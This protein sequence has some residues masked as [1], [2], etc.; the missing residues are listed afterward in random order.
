MRTC[1]PIFVLLWLLS[2]PARAQ[3]A[4]EAAREALRTGQYEDAR[5]RFRVLLEAPDEGATAYAAG[6]ADAFLK[7]GA[8]DEGL[9]AFEALLPRHPGN[10]DLLLA[11]S[12]L[13]VAR[14]RYA[15]AEAALTQA[16]RA[17]SDCWACAYVLGRLFED[18][19][20][21]RQA[22]RL[23]AAVFRRYQEGAFGTADD[24]G[25]AAR[26]AARL[27][28]FRDANEAFR[29]A[30]RMD[31]RH[32]DNLGAW[33]ALFQEKYNTA[34]AQ[35]TYEEALAVNP[36]DADLYAGYATTFGSFAR[37]E[38]LARK[39]L[40]VNPRHAGALSLLAGLHLLDREDAQAEAR[41]R[42]AL[43]VNPFYM[44]ALAHLAAVHYLRGDSAAFADVEGRALAVNPRAGD[45]YIT[46]AEDAELRFRYADAVDF[47]RRAVAVENDN[48]RAYATLGTGLLRV[49][50]Y[51]EAR[52]YLE[53]SLDRDPFNLFVANTLTLLD[54]RRDAFER[55]ESAHFTLYIHRSEADVLGPAMLALAETCYAD[56]SARYPYT[57]Q[58]K[59]TLEAYNDHD[60]FGVRVAG[61]PHLSLLGVSFGDIVA[62][63]TPRAQ[64]GND[65]NW[66]RTLWH[67]IAHTMAIGVSKHRVPRWFTEGLSVYEERRARPEWGRELDLAFFS[68]LD[69]GKL[70]PLTDIDRG[71]TRPAFPRQVI[72]SY[73]HAARVIGFIVDRYGFQAVTEILVA[74]GQGRSID[75]SI[76]AVLGH[77]TAEL[78]RA[79]QASLVGER[80]RLADVLRDLPDLL[81][82]ASDAAAPPSGGNAFFRSLEEGQLLL[83]QRQYDAAEARFK[84]ALALY[85]G[86][87][88]AGSPYH[89]LAAVYRER[90]DRELLADVLERFLRVSEYGAAEARELAALH[91]D[92]GRLDEAL[93]YLTR[94]LDVDPYHAPTYEALADLYTR[95]SDHARAVQARR[96]LLALDPLDR[97]EALFHLAESLYRNQQNDEARRTVLRALELA[98]GHREAQK[99]LLR[100][101]D[102]G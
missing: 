82:D 55:R 96:A 20:R 97:A 79:F 89:G 26:A 3:D 90:G 42:E 53:V 95:R 12:R 31:A 69:Q 28:V 38:Q 99:L 24:L 4:G 56:L 78:D 37:K 62:M 15:E 68:A 64:A 30:H 80:D 87:V 51:P 67:E 86:Y 75:E 101:V 45:F 76:A 14:G 59:I 50:R 44:P 36:H 9:A 19:G 65:Y 18:T 2:V 70:L 17:R 39:A 72:L 91:A 77:T 47:A 21:R 40:E 27:G 23:Y 13:L 88:A 54:E 22:L 66:A 63:D 8:Y 10:A 61:L 34:D 25:L 43:A 58:G 84:E 81:G 11:R 83:R 102:A 73:Y 48:A 35:Q 16:L 5:A 60:D 49:G 57:P 94:S 33:A 92:A 29:L 41:A 100:C 93:T 74:L 98:P 71:F 6:Y 52:R 46:L 7:A 1:F 85:P 32:P